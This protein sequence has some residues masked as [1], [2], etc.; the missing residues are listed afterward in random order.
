MT[1]DGLL[2][3]K[4]F[5]F[6]FLAGLFVGLFLDL[7][8]LLRSL[9]GLAQLSPTPTYYERS[10]PLIGRPL[11]RPREKRFYIA[12]VKCLGAL[13]ALLL[14]PLA[15]MLLAIVTFSYND[16]VLR[17][18]TIFLLVIGFFLWRALVSR[19]LAPVLCMIAF[20]VQVLLLYVRALFLW[21]LRLVWKALH[22]VLLSPCLWCART[23]LN[24]LSEARTASLCKYELAAARCG[25]GILTQRLY[26]KEDKHGKT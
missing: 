12:L 10:L 26:K 6:S 5:L 11:R 8:G 24:R 18:L 7:L 2:Q 23:L 16:G 15:A 4:L 20:G 22:A 1:V 13:D 17:P 14:P 3:A 21:V 19:R 9:F 25:F